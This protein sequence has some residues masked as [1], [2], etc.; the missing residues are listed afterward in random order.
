MLALEWYPEVILALAALLTAVA[1]VL[2]GIA[3]LR[4]TREKTRKTAEEECLERL[5][6]ARR[7]SES[8]ARELHDLRMKEQLG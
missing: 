8:V 3:A 7:E 4:R 6:E 1:G 2:T 5:R